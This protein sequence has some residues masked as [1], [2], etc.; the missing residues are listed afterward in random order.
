M[1][2]E[3]RRRQQRR[4]RSRSCG[5]YRDRL[6]AIASQGRGRYKKEPLEKCPISAGSAE[7][8]TPAKRL[9]IGQPNVRTR[10]AIIKKQDPEPVK[11]EPIEQDA[12]E[13]EDLPDLEEI[14]RSAGK[15]M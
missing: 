4:C 8:N 2:S 10:A 5:T 11:E 14:L 3:R 1:T 12:T 7:R 9:P 15:K 6:S 13:G